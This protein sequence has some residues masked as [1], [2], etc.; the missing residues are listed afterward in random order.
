MLM[1]CFCV[2]AHCQI[3]S[4]KWKLTSRER[5]DA[6]MRC[7]FMPVLARRATIVPLIIQG[8]PLVIP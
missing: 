4:S 2:E 1:F 6:D 7:R 5:D 3:S 8:E